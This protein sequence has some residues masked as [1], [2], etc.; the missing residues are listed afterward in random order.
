MLRVGLVVKEG[1]E[2][3][4]PTVAGGKIEYHSGGRY[5]AFVVVVDN[6]KVVSKTGHGDIRG[7]K[8]GLVIDIPKTNKNL[9]PVA[10][11]NTQG[12]ILLQTIVKEKIVQQPVPVASLNSS[13]GSNLSNNKLYN[14]ISGSIG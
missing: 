4:T 10:S 7:A 14:E 1:A 2:I 3:V 6:G 8:D 11:S 12:S 9:G 13:G 5:G